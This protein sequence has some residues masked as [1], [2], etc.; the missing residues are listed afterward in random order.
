M[1][2]LAVFLNKVAEFFDE[3]MS[4]APDKFIFNLELGYILE[5][6]SSDKMTIG[7]PL[8]TL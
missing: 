5:I 3:V 4:V 8:R 1:N 2:R 6:L 7:V